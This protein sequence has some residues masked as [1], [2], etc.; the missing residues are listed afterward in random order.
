MSKLED[1]NTEL[2]GLGIKM[3]QNKEMD[4]TATNVDP[5]VNK[6]GANIIQYKQ[7]DHTQRDRY[8]FDNQYTEDSKLVIEAV[9][10]FRN[11]NDE[12]SRRKWGV[13]HELWQSIRG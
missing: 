13:G 8:W 11:R 2:C 5:E 12:N 9:K 1:I 4:Q 7:K 6:T 10:M 3:I